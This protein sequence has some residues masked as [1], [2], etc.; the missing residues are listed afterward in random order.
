MTLEKYQKQIGKNIKEARENAELRQI[1]IEERIGLTYRY[2]QSIE[3][4]KAN[5]TVKTLF[6][7]SKLFKTSVES[8]VRQK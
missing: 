2:Y 8:L 4:G 5:V 3:A 6:E 7:L 1:D